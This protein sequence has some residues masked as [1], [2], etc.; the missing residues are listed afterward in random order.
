MNPEMFVL[1]VFCVVKESF[2]SGNVSWAIAQ[3]IKQACNV[4]GLKLA[5]ST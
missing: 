3:I 5:L 2:K 4:I 1:S